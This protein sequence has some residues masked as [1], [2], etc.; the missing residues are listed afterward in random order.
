MSSTKSASS[1]SHHTHAISS[2]NNNDD[3][4]NNHDSSN[5]DNNHN[6]KH[7]LNEA[8]VTL[9]PEQYLE[10]QV[11]PE[12][13]F[14][15]SSS[16]NPIN[17]LDEVNVPASPFVDTLDECMNI[18][19]SSSSFVTTWS[20]SSIGANLELSDDLQTVTQTVKQGRAVLA[21][22]PIHR[23][24]V[25]LVAGSNKMLIGFVPRGADFDP[26]EP[27]YTSVGWYLYLLDGTLW[28]QQGDINRPYLKHS[29]TGPHERHTSLLDAV[30][31]T[32]TAIWDK[33]K[34]EIAFEAHDGTSLGVAFMN[35]PAQL[36]LVPAAVFFQAGDAVRLVNSSRQP[37][38]PLAAQVA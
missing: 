7:N 21:S 17:I 16:E 26:S 23:F 12:F 5:N 8:P 20:S 6:E 14:P 15:S 4:D 30:G 34:G 33:D 35:V 18:P 22:E 3:H 32:L 10:T 37:L 24:T 11:A 29:T 28:S 36:K 25:E 19:Q 31:Q 13:S 2:S 27:L 9:V 1:A 38:N